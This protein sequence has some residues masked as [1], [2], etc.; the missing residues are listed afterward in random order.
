[1]V[2]YQLFQDMTFS[3]CKTF[4]P[5][6]CSL[7]GF[8]C[9]SVVVRVNLYNKQSSSQSTNN[10]VFKCKINE[11]YHNILWTFSN[12]RIDNPKHCWSNVSWDMSVLCQSQRRLLLEWQQEDAVRV[13]CPF[14]PRLKLQP[15]AEP[16]FE[17]QSQGERS[18]SRGCCRATKHVW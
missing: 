1:M 6:N 14:E 16:L 3:S 8:F 15:A 13:W 2:L 9:G 4:F 5:M 7:T 18:L 17:L 11:Q 12:N 10:V